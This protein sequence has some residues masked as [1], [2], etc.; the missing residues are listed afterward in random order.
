MR[1]KPAVA[2]VGDVYVSEKITFIVIQ[3]DHYGR[4]YCL[5]TRA[6]NTYGLSIGYIKSFRENMFSYAT[7][8]AYVGKGLNI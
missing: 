2:T 5:C 4:I 6:V 3:K 7:S 1:R 8:Y